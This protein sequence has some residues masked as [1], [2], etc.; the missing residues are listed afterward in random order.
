MGSKKIGLEILKIL[1]TNTKKLNYEI[2]AILTNKR[3]TEIKEFAK[4]HNLPL[5]NSLDEY[6]KLSDVDI[7]ISIQ[8]HEILKKIHIQKAKELT[9]NLHMAPLP[10]Y[11]GCNQFTFAILDNAKVFGTT[12]HKLSKEIDAGEILFE[13]RFDIPK[14][15]WVEDLYKLTFDASILLF[16]QH[17]KDIIEVSIDPISQEKF[18]QQRGCSIHYRNEIEK[19]KQIDLNWDSQKIKRHIMATSM[20]GFEPPYTIINNQKVYFQLSSQKKGSL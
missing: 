11:R 14:Y 5:I 4:T 8:Y 18:I 17:L 1:Q 12:I 3:G 16:E 2:V 6:L 19:V 10:E 9:I 15:C 13:K 20:N 7:A